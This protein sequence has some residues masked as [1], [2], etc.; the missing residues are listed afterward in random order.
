MNLIDL[1]VTTYTEG[2]S[3]AEDQAA[4]QAAQEQAQFLKYARGCAGSTLAHAAAELDWQYTAADR[5]PDQ[6]EEARALLSPGRLEYLRYRMDHHTD[7]DATV[8][9]ELVQPCW[10][11]GQDRISPVA[12][13]FQLGQLLAETDDQ[14]HGGDEDQAQEPGPLAA[15]EE[16]ETHMARLTRLARRLLIEHPDA[17]LTVQYVSLFGHENGGGRAEVHF[18]ADGLGALFEVAGA[19][20]AE[21]TVKVSSTHPSYVFEHGTARVT[22]GGVDVELTGYRKL[23]DDEAATWRAQQDQADEDG[24]A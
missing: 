1:A 7:P 24:A 8:D 11:C 22:V 2:G 10:A 23:P 19:L 21:V 13:L 20:G 16:L 12:S 15:V 17:G 6:V 4:E 18:K 14:A 3:S 5:L 9:L